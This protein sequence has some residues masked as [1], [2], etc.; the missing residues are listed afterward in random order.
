MSSDTDSPVS[1]QATIERPIG[2]PTQFP[3]P[4]NIHQAPGN[5][6]AEMVLGPTGP[7]RPL[8][9]RYL[10]TVVPSYYKPGTLIQV[11]SSIGK[12]FRFVVQDQHIEDLDQI[13]P[14]TI[15][16]FIEMER[17]RGLTAINFIGHIS[18][19][20]VWL[21]SLELYD[22]GNPVISRLHRPKMSSQ[23]GSCFTSR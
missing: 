11:R 6:R 12:F 4:R 7:F 19:F 20:F 23:S 18:S 2:S 15:T 21:I 9:E 5:R 10:T 16:R 13:R 1:S 3:Q 22:R 14:S 17:E 8:I